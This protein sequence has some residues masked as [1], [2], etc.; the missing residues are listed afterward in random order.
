MK[1]CIYLLVCVLLLSACG[2]KEFEGKNPK[3][4]KVGIENE[5][6]TI[7][8]PDSAPYFWLEKVND[9]SVEYSKLYFQFDK[10]TQGYIYK[11]DLADWKPI[12]TKEPI[13]MGQVNISVGEK[14]VI[15]YPSGTWAFP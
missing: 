11:T 12:N 4:A 10:D 15:T 6:V 8:L 9:E 3:E 13:K 7:T 5:I 14:I 2:S 1:K